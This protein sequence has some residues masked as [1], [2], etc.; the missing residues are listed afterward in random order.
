MKK[1]TN[2]EMRITSAMM[3]AALLMSMTGC[4]QTQNPQTQP[5]QPAA[6]EPAAEAQPA[7][8]TAEEL[9]FAI[10][11]EKMPPAPEAASQLKYMAEQVDV[12]LGDPAKSSHYE[13]AVSDLDQD[14][15]LEIIQACTGGPGNQTFF[16]IRE[17]TTDGKE[18]KPALSL[19]L[20]QAGADGQT[21]PDIIVDSTRAYQLPNGQIRYLLTDVLRVDELTTNTTVWTAGLLDGAVSLEKVA[22]ASTQKTEEGVSKTLYFNSE[23]GSIEESMFRNLP[24][25]MYQSA[26]PGMLSIGWIDNMEFRSGAVALVQEALEQSYGKFSVS[27]EKEAAA[28]A[29][30]SGRSAVHPLGLLRSESHFVK[31]SESGTRQILYLSAE[32]LQLDD[33]TAALYPALARSLAL[34]SEDYTVSAESAAEEGDEVNEAYNASPD[35]FRTITQITT[36]RP[37]RA[38]SSLL[39]ILVTVQGTR[40][41][42]D[43]LTVNGITFDPATGE[44]LFLT[45]LVKDWE[46]LGRALKEAAQAQYGE[47]LSETAEEEIDHMLLYGGRNASWTADPQGLTFYMS[48]GTIAP[49]EQGILPVLVFTKGNESLYAESVKNV[50]KAYAVFPVIGT[51]LYYDLNED[52][53]ADRILLSHDLTRYAM[54]GKMTVSVNGN[55]AG[56]GILH[57]SADAVL[58]HTADGRNYLYTEFT[59]AEDDRKIHVYDLNEETPSVA[60]GKSLGFATEENAAYGRQRRLATNPDRILLDA[61][62]NLMST[63]EARQYCT[64]GEDGLPVPDRE[65]Y[66]IHTQHTLTTK[67]FFTAD[68]LDPKKREVT[69]QTNIATGTVLTFDRTDGGSYVDFKLPDE[70]IIRLYPSGYSRFNGDLDAEEYLSNIWFRD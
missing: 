46:G 15:Y 20:L 66:E 45:D 2:R 54:K 44:R 39:S 37:H 38:D 32:G 62:I 7:G 24:D 49:A 40:A 48:P 3:T 12:W 30:R 56:D 14:E 21:L 68:V 25:L 69:G 52:G 1:F 19:T 57:N 29:D 36:M 64:I 31:F 65:D 55:A 8:Q 17:I 33:E 22:S 47:L 23:G 60:G 70:R 6:Q 67:K 18:K 10:E 59:Q 61:H 11:E 53:A 34:Q 43:S 63:Y 9:G 28:M 42:G 27:F 16:E 26:Q 51:S 5:A 4:G 58:L 13:Y 35:S 41:W 50:P